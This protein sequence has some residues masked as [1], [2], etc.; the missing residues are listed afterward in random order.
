[1]HDASCALVADGQVVAAAEEERFSR[2]KHVTGFPTQAMRYCLE[3]AGLQPSELDV[4]VASWRTRDAGW[5]LTSAA[6]ARRSLE[7]IGASGR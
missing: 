1:M 6:S 4:V 5:R 2:V 3:V 7:S